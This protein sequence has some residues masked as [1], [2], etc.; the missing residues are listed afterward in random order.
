MLSQIQKRAKKMYDRVI[1]GKDEQLQNNS[2]M[3]LRL[4]EACKEYDVNQ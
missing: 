2:C 1:S 4:E 3:F